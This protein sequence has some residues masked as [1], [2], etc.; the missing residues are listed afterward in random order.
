MDSSQIKSHILSFLAKDC[1]LDVH[2]ISMDSP[3][4]SS[5]M[6]SSLDLIDLISF[7]EREFGIHIP[8]EDI[9]H[10][11]LDNIERIIA[12]INGQQRA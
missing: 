4:F 11:N 1:Y 8:G 10:S 3:L 9:S 12:Y 5:Q 7:L 6:L 2:N